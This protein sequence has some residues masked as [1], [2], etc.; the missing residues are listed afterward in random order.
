MTNRRVIIEGKRTIVLKNGPHAEGTGSRPGET[1]FEQ[2]DRY[3]RDE[4]DKDQRHIDEYYDD[5]RDAEDGT[6]TTT[7]AAAANKPWI[8][9]V[10][11]CRRWWIWGWEPLKRRGDSDPVRAYHPGDDTPVQDPLW[12]GRTLD[13]GNL[14]ALSRILN[15]QPI[16]KEWAT[17]DMSAEFAGVHDDLTNLYER[18]RD[19]RATKTQKGLWLEQLRGSGNAPDRTDEDMIFVIHTMLILIAR[20][21][22]TGRRPDDDQKVTEG[23]VQWV[24]LADVPSLKAVIGKYDW[25]RQPGDIMRSLYHHYVPPEHRQIYGEYYTP[26]WLAELVCQKVID[27]GFIGAQL[28]NF[29]GKKHV[30]GVLVP[31][32]GSG[33]FLYQAALRV[34]RS[35]PVRNSGRE[36]S[37]I[38]EFVC[39]MVCGMDIHPVAVEMARTNMRRL[40]PRVP[41]S[42]IRVYQGDSLLTPRPDVHLYHHSMGAESLLLQ[43][44]R[45]SRLIMPGWFVKSAPDVSAFVKTARD[46]RD[47]PE[48]L[49]SHLEGYDRNALAEAHVRLR[50]IIREED[51]GV[52]KWFIL[53]QAGPLNIRQ[54]AGRIISNPPWVRNSKIRVKSRKEEI[55]QMAKERGLW[56]GGRV[57]TS[58]DIASLFVD[59]C[60]YLYMDKPEGRRT[61]GWVIPHG[62]LDG[63]GWEKFREKL[64][65]MITGRWNLKRLPFPNT[66]TAA[67][68]F[69]LK[70]MP[71]WDFA[72]K[73]RTNLDPNDSWENA[74]AKINLNEMQKRFP[75]ERSEW[76]GGRKATPI[77]RN[78]ATI[79]PHCLTWIESE[80]PARTDGNG[81]NMVRITTRASAK[82]PWSSLGGQRG[83]I[84][85][86]WIADCI[87]TADLIPYWLPT[88][89]R[90]LLP[91]SGNNW[92]P[93]RGKNAFWKNA[94]DLY[95]ANCGIGQS[96]PKTLERRL[97]HNGALFKQFDRTGEQVV[98]NVSGDRLYAARVRNP[99]HIASW[100]VFSVPCRTRDE[101][102]FLISALNAECMLPA[103]K[104]AQ[105]SDRDFSSHIWKK[106]PIPRYDKHDPLH[107]RLAHLGKKAED[108]ARRSYDPDLGIQSMRNQTRQILR[109]DGTGQKIDDICR[110][111][112]PE[113]AL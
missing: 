55:E 47:L 100:K 37:E 53:N 105:Q 3:V 6:V 65:S 19:L 66:P 97:D 14:A 56:T 20:M 74:S 86:S 67:I 99:K 18:R 10:T 13:R 41:D 79:V 112:F 17:S 22:S 25:N 111:I 82:T 76:I 95:E 81:R 80:S 12:Q 64:G 5:D 26:D 58:F 29:L 78:G 21:I 44:P 63:E 103:F 2:V 102:M 43:S 16:G 96:T 49:G 4:R 42:A 36:H 70:D 73:R 90:C 30:R 92:D 109:E 94:S 104:G 31:A 75:I 48:G 35:D 83:T 40:F 52:W 51:N 9:V 33:T 69:G 61:S 15:R 93:N 84:P 54:S 72:K 89:T 60:M 113:H 27:D 88:T 1:A 45:G 71:S 106:I 62:S 91:L 46:D 98:Y 32:C 87:S 24:S 50:I 107:V 59:R 8:G 68:F 7:A 57:S 101:S 110:K 34:L 85:A 28:A 38:A 108:I 23:F 39:R 11:D 77:A